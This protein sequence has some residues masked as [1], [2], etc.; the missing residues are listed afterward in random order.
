[1]KRCVNVFLGHQP[2]PVFTKQ[3][4]GAK[5]TG[6]IYDGHVARMLYTVAALATRT[7]LVELAPLLSKPLLV[8]RL[9]FRALTS[10]SSPAEHHPPPTSPPKLAFPPNLPQCSSSP[11]VATP[12]P[13]HA[14][15][16]CH[17]PSAPTMHSPLP[18]SRSGEGARHVLRQEEAQGGRVGRPRVKRMR[19]FRRPQ[20]NSGVVVMVVMAVMAVQCIMT[21]A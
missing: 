14:P 6:Y 13:P 4:V 15:S 5:M 3:R 12:P 9:S 10:S 16:P 8:L 17:R 7:L 2:K 1:M 11:W 21:V 20:L 19:V 18:L